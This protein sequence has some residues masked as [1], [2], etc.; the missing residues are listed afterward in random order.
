VQT[1]AA[2]SRIHLRRIRAPFAHGVRCIIFA[3]ACSLGLSEAVAEEAFASLAARAA[4]ARDANRLDEAST[5]YLQALALQPQ[6]KDGWWSLGTIYYDRDQY[7]QAIPAFQHLLTIDPKNGTGYAMLGLCEFELGQDAAALHDIQ[8]GLG[9]GLL[10]DEPLRKVVLYHEGILL[11]R[12]GRFGSA[13]SALSL[14]ASYGVKDDQLAMALGMAVLSVAP[15]NLPAGSQEREIVL[16][17]GRAEILAAQKDLD[18]GKKIYASLVAQASKFPN[19]HYAYGR[20]LLLA[21]Q[22]EEA[23]AEFQQEI[24]NNPRHTRAYLSIAAARYRLDSAAGVEYAA[25]AVRLDPALP[26]GHYMLG[27]LYA[28]SHDYAKAVPEL[29][30]AAQKMNRPDIYYALGNAYARLGRDQDATRAREIFRRLSAEGDSQDRPNIYG[31]NPPV[32]VDAEGTPG[33]EHAPD[34]EG[35]NPHP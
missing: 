10:T 8:T 22:P 28:D 25:D 29:E 1:C 9:F 17:A 21:H 16:W 34:H 12:Q 30:L 5:L 13:Q 3:V 18:R 23:I 15:Q 27:L 35:E 33:E 14:L 31:D 24:K 20:Y 11:L 19:L 32:Q 4:A 7:S 2:G 26:F 6:W